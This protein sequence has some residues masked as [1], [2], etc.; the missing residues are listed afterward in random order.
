VSPAKRR[1]P[2]DF[3]RAAD[4]SMTL[5]EHLRELRS[6]LF[7]ACLALVLITMKNIV[8]CDKYC[9]LQKIYKCESTNL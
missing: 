2:S 4:G 9:E 5:I 6:R 3:Q 8:N 7:K 1:K